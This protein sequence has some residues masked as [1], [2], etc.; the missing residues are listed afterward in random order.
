MAVSVRRE[1]KA[2]AIYAQTRPEK[3]GDILARL[4]GV[5]PRPPVNEHPLLGDYVW[6]GGEWVWRKR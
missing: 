4:P 1:R 6:S 3:L 2:A 5:P